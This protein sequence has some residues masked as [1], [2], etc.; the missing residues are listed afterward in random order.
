MMNTEAIDTHTVPMSSAFLTH[1]R[2]VVLDTIQQA[3]ELRDHPPQALVAPVQL[4][5]L[6][7]EERCSAVQLLD[8]RIASSL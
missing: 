7:T 6:S 5:D 4:R 1:L 8:S 2:R 3:F